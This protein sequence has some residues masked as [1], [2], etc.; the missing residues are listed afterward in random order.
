MCRNL[1]NEK[2]GD[3]SSDW[4]ATA[5]AVILLLVIDVWLKQSKIYKKTKAIE[6]SLKEISDLLEDQGR[7]HVDNEV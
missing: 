3:M 6:L 4:I 1:V 2:A 7:F 5:L